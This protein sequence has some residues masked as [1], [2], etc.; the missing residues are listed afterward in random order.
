[1][2]KVFKEAPYSSAYFWTF[3]RYVYVN[4]YI[5]FFSTRHENR[6]ALEY[7]EAILDNVT[8]TIATW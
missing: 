8:V 4:E 6:T 7:L 3:Q 1:M 5:I 2:K